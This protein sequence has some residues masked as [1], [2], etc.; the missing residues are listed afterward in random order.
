MEDVFRLR[1]NAIEGKYRVDEPAGEGGF[2]VVYR[3]WHLTFEHAIAIKC[4][5]VPHHFTED[6]KRLRRIKLC[7]GPLPIASLM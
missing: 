4:L 7:G 5:K 6:A 1:G 2:G 3:G